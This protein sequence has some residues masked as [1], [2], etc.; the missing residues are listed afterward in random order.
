MQGGLGE[1]Y[2]I[3]K[4]TL[5]KRDLAILVTKQAIFVVLLLCVICRIC[6]NLDV[7]RVL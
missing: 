3:V 5:S 6:F 4:C 7:S 2:Q 1:L